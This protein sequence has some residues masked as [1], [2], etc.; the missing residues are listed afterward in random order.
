MNGFVNRKNVFSIIAAAGTV[1]IASLALG[2]GPPPPPNRP[3]PPPLPPVPVP[4]GNQFSAAKA[5]LGKILFMDEQLSADNTTACVTC[6]QVNRGGVDPRH[7]RNPGV[8]GIL[9]NG[10]DAVA[11]PGVIKSDALA[12]YVRDTV[13]GLAPQVTPR[14]AMPMINAAYAPTLFWDGRASGTFTDPQTGT[15]ALDNGGAFE[16]QSVG[17]PDNDVEM[18]HADRDWTQ[19]TAKIAHSKPLALATNLPANAAAAIAANPTYPL[20]FQAAFGDGRVTARRIAFAIATYERTLISNQSPFDRFSAGIPGALT[21]QQQAGWNAFNAS[22]CVACHTGPNLTSNGFRNVGLRPFAEDTGQSAI[23][24]NPADRGKFKVPNLRNVGLRSGFMHNGQFTTLN[25]VLGFYA[26]APGA[27]LQ[28][29]AGNNQDPLMA[30]VNVPPQAVAPILEFLNNAL[31]D[32]RVRDGLAPFDSV[33]LASQR[34]G[35]QPVTLGAGTAGSGAI[36]PVVIANMPSL[37]GSSEFRI[38]IDRARGGAIARLVRSEAPPGANSVLANAVVVGTITLTG[39]GAGNGYGTAHLP[40]PSDGSLDG[41]SVYYQWLVTD[42]A[43]T[44]GTA[45]SAPVRVTYFCGVG[46]CG[47]DCP[48]DIASGSGEAPG[49]G[50]VDGSDFIAF[51]NGFSSGSAIADIAAGGG[52]PGPDGMVDGDDFIAFINAFASGC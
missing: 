50:I 36:V 18:A 5:V 32:T 30:T 37:I 9:G 34:P 35:V 6:H 16:S 38:G 21:A 15:V 3:A 13:F 29:I 39:A 40:I 23:T 20:L 27:A 41:T 24:N 44:G 26:R 8:D 43:A 31:L 12:D 42:A 22:N 28:F 49:D 46:G 25:E 11:S 10:D 45:Y 7:A 33:T 2:Q 48:A 52:L 14:T 51:I 19:I 1:A 17:P 47:S 4:P